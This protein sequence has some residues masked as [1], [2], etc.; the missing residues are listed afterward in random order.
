VKARPL[1]ICAASF[2]WLV[3]AAMLLAYGALAPVLGFPARP[4]V[5]IHIVALIVLVFGYAYW[6]IAG[7]PARFRDY[8]ILGIVGKLAF[9][10]AIYAHYV[11]GDAPAAL[12]VLV[13]TDLVFAALFAWYLKTHPAAADA[14]L[15]RSSTS[16][17]S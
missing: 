4:S 11:A 10:V 6:R 2:N 9:V 13:T 5:W 3:G 7:D 17:Q 14:V 8:V 15:V 12:A 1:F 16:R